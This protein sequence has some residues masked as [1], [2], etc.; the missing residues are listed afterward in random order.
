MDLIKFGDAEYE[1]S[2]LCFSRLTSDETI[3]MQLPFVGEKRVYSI[4]ILMV[5]KI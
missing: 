2:T 4:N 5:L 1:K 3:A